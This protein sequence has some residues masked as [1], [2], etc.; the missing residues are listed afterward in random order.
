MK[1]TSLSINIQGPCDAQ[2]PYC[3]A[4]ETWKT[5][6]RGTRLTMS[7]LDK[8]YRYAKWHGV[9]TVLV[10]GSGEPTERFEAAIGAIRTAE[11]YGFPCIEMQTNGYNLWAD[12]DKLARLV[13]KGLTTLSISIS[14]PDPK[15]SA[16]MVKL[17]SD[18]N[19]M[20][21]IR[22]ANDLGLMV[23]VSLNLSKG[24]FPSGKVRDGYMAWLPEF[25]KTIKAAGAHQL[26]LR[27][28][29]MPTGADESHK[30]VQWWKANRTTDEQ[31][32]AVVT[33]V[34]WGRNQLRK[35]SYG[36]MVYQFEGLGTTISTCM[37]DT[38]NPDE[39][40]SLILQPDGH[41]YHTWGEGS[42]LV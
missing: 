16:E 24:V 15:I 28:L 14:H 6:M 22:Q 26:T 38:T 33:V 42:I 37:T 18:Y 20:D 40:R 31:M 27:E 41:L 3:I 11:E 17:P 8:A 5:G 39:I 23:R 34:T 21:L 35:L 32:D 13:Q 36:N 19:Y 2:C 7:A 30:T 1:A 9:D 10:T 12:T 25:A 29:G 4:R